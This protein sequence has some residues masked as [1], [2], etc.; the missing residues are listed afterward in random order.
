MI[1]SADVAAGDRYAGDERCDT[2][3]DRLL[4]MDR[5]GRPSREVLVGDQVALANDH[6]RVLGLGAA[7]AA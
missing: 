6:E 1:D 7:A 3:G 2:L 4:R 5:V